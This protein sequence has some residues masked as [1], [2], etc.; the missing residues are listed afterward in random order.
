MSPLLKEVA[1]TAGNRAFFALP[2]SL[3][4]ILNSV[5]AEKL[6]SLHVASGY[7]ARAE[8]QALRKWLC[9]PQPNIQQHEVSALQ[10]QPSFNQPAL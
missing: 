6:W 3:V 4:L 5:L 7:E 9:P 1:M 2:K 8:M 10:E